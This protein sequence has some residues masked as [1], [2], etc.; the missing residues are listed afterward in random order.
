M[1]NTSIRL[2]KISFSCF[3]FILCC[4]ICILFFSIN[5]TS[6]NNIVWSEDWETGIGRWFASN[7]VWE[8]GVPMSSPPGKSHSGQ[9]CAGTILSGLYPDNADTRLVSPEIT[10]PGLST[11]EKMQLRFWHWFA[12]FPEDPGVVQI[13]TDN[14]TTWKTISNKFDWNS[15]AW[16]QYIVDISSYA[17][18]TVRFAFYF[19]SNGNNRANGWYIDDVSIVKGVFTMRNPEDFE[20][21]IGD[22]FADKGIW[23]VGVPTA[24]PDTSYTVPNCAGAVL[25][26]FY[27]ANANSR[28]ISPETRLVPKTG[29]KPELFFWHWFNIFPEDSAFVQISVERGPWQKISRSFNSN[30]GWTQFWI[31]LSP[32]INSTVRFAFYFASNG[33]NQANGWYIDDIRIEG[34]DATTIGISEDQTSK[35]TEFALFQNYPNPFNPSTTFKFSIPYSIHVVLKI[36]DVLGKEVSTLVDEELPMGQHKM[37]WNVH[38]LASGVYIYKIQAGEFVQTRKMILMR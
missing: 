9:R 20:L 7:G 19:I 27:P 5:A 38:N 1:K 18:S 23:E 35:P 15:D 25:G 11:N 34:I 26:G 4:L 6:Q 22:W 10:L 8:V 16:T 14:G 37:N 24:G 33:S 29:Q 30:S 28:L 36:Y 2:F 13:S 17:N 31:D 32:Y 12:Q 3:W 21:G